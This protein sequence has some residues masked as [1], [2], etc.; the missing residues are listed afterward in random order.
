VVAWLVLG[1]WFLAPHLVRTGGGARELTYSAFLSD[2]DHHEVA[3]VAVGSAGQITGALT[4]G[5]DFTVQAPP[6][7]LTTDDLASRLEGAHVHV[8][9]FQQGGSTLGQLAVSLL[10]VLVLV[11][12][13]WWMG[14]R[15]QRALG[16][17]GGGLAGLG[18]PLSARGCAGAARAA[19]GRAARHR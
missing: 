3:S 13:F 2:V 18:G 5:R 9:A 15:T 14:Q 6:W 19:P 10:P 4:N 11:G 12:A 8:T 17:G 1:A 16:S 7:A